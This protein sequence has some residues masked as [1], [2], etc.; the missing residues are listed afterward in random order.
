MSHLKDKILDAEV[1]L[2]I[3]GGYDDM[4]PKP[5]SAPVRVG[6]VGH[7]KGNSDVTRHRILVI[8]CDMVA[9]IGM[10]N[11]RRDAIAR[12]A[13]VG[14]GTV[15]LHFGDMEGL[16]HA[17]MTH[18]VHTERLE[19]IAMGLANGDPVAIK[20]SKALRVK[21]LQTLI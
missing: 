18:A 21:A 12:R 7:V 19:I 2:A 4:Y 3:D 1:G 9:K 8:A 20:A 5:D 16:R 15:S 11:I 10:S 17:I 14:M 6:K 13:G